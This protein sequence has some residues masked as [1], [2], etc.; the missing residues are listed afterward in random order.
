MISG[1]GGVGSEYVIARRSKEGKK[2]YIPSG[3]DSARAEK[4]EIEEALGLDLLRVLLT[5]NS[6]A[7][8]GTLIILP[9][10]EKFHRPLGA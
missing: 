6:L 2:V 10:R 1:T 5:G 3:P 8:D 4:Q 7:Q 9:S